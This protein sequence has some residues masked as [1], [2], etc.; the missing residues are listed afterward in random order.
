MGFG[1]PNEE[2]LK[3]INKFAR[4]P[5]SAEQ[6]F[7]FDAK[8][9]GDGI[10]PTRFMRLT[11]PLLED[12]NRDANA[13]IAFM[14]DHSWSGFFARPKAAFTYG[15]SYSSELKPSTDG[16]EGEKLAQFGEIYIV[17]DREKDGIATNQLIADIED[18]VLFDLSIG[19]QFS[20]ALCSICEENIWSMKCEHWPGK[21]YDGKLCVAEAQA[22]GTQMEISGVFDGAYPSAG[23]LSSAGVLSPKVPEG[24]DSILHGEDFKKI[25]EG[26]T[27]LC[28][29][30][31]VKHNAVP[32]VSKDFI[33]KTTMVSL[34]EEGGANMDQENKVDPVLTGDGT[35][36]A[37]PPIEE[38]KEND[39][40]FAE[41]QAPATAEPESADAQPTEAQ[42]ASQATQPESLSIATS[43]V[44]AALGSDFTA[45]AIL[46]LAKDG[47]KHR[48]ALV[49]EALAWGVRAHGNDFAT[50]HW[51]VVLNE[52]SRT[53]EALQ[54]FLDQFKREAEGKI[55]AGRTSSIQEPTPAEGTK[56]FTPDAAFKV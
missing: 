42:D 35:G 19:F 50:E 40:R 30:N 15:R 31:P 5:L 37:L 21:T 54:A 32:L 18:G 16:P 28:A 11:K 22:P 27:I 13:G 14:L 44:R 23:I 25:E 43:D 48:Q 20:V 55:P 17:R 1:T 49:E 24:M 56:K 29:Y 53:V 4:R 52:P 45:D 10:I 33:K 26:A 41:G 9:V 12:F 6:V 3:K 8:F 38:G 47:L 36:A 34:S 2:Q 46:A 51:S 7:T 39:E